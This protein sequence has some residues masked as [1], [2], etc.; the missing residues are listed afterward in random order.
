MKTVY[1]FGWDDD[2][3]LGVYVKHPSSPDP[4]LI[5]A[6]LFEKYQM[7]YG[8]PD[9]AEWRT[10][11]DYM[12]SAEIELKPGDGVRLPDAV[13]P[14]FGFAAAGAL[15]RLQRIEREGKWVPVNDEQRFKK[16]EGGAE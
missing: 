11:G 8:D 6:Q 13:R 3:L 7:G 12:T 9:P 16:T 1:D 5:E 2:G 10:I 4:V 14:V 15:K